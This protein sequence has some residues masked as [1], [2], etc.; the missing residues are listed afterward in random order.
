MTDESCLAPGFK[1][2]PFWWD[3]APLPRL[4]ETGEG[5]ATDVAIVGSGYTGL[6]AALHLLRGGRSVTILDAED[7][8]FGASRRN[9]GYIGRTLKR[10][11]TWLA[12]RYGLDHAIA[13]YRELDDALKLVQR[14]IAEEGIDCH[15][16]LCGRFIGA[17]SPAHFEI[18]ARD[19]A[20]MKRHLGFD[21][22][23]LSR[24]EQRAEM[25]TD[26]YFGGAVIPDLGALHPGLYHKG[27]LDRV[28]AAGGVV[29]PRAPVLG[30][31][32]AE[33]GGRF[34]LRTSRGEVSARDVIVATNGYTPAEFPWHARRVIPFSAYMAA[35]EPLGPERMARL[36]PNGRTCIETQMN[37]TY[38]RPAPDGS[39]ILFGGLTGSTT[40]SVSAIAPRLRDLLTRV[41][42]DL[43][44]VKL[45]HA[46]TGKCAG[47]FDFMPHIGVAGGIH[48]ALG[49]NFAGVPM[50]TWLG[51]KLALKILG[52]AEGSSAFERHAPP[53]LP[54]YGGKPWFVPLAM[55]YFGWHDRRIAAR[56]AGKAT[57]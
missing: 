14:L 57:G 54:L 9:A 49:Y 42:P 15:L 35:T 8:G 47:T 56:G 12:E 31:D 22:H 30:I 20:A 46:W 1:E 45:S 32:A 18:L 33:G 6:S 4:P 40:P 34:R 23:M 52:S 11:V 50:G 16:T 36:I 53:T 10:D 43:D 19:L 48:Y 44:G 17:T 38:I 39:R 26:F 55:K 2:Q 24:T 13:I 3:A 25:A 51:R 7:A 21:F 41:L 5:T 37:I 27:L 28:I 29:R